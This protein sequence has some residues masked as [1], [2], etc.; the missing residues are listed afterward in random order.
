MD[1]DDEIIDRLYPRYKLEDYPDIETAAF[2]KEINIAYAVCSNK[3]GVQQF[4][5][6]GSTQICEYCCR[7]M[8]KKRVLRYVL[9]EEHKE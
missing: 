6:E 9:A 4:I 8:L 1:N 2:P 7:K 3:C 5:V